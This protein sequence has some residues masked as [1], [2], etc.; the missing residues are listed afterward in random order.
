MKSGMYWTGATT[1]VR[2]VIWPYK[3]LYIAARKS[4]AYQGIAMPFF[5]QGYRIIMECE[6]GAIKERMAS[7]LKELMLCGWGRS[8]T[9]HSIW[10][11]HAAGAGHASRCTW[12]DEAEKL[13]VRRAHHRPSHQS[14]NVYPMLPVNKDNHSSTIIV[15][16]NIWTPSPLQRGTFNHGPACNPCLSR[17]LVHNTT[18]A[19]LCC[20]FHSHYG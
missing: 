6:E 18:S 3:V 8:R 1:L 7:H 14:C 10:L 12:H 20:V 2:K 4:T 13:T 5:I 17:L 16:T 11:N 19:C 15:I 9:F